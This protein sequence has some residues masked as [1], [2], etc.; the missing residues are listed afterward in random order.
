M[1]TELTFIDERLKGKRINTI[2]NWVFI[3]AQNEI[4]WV[5]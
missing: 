5:K 1:R 3:D 2:Q 4:L